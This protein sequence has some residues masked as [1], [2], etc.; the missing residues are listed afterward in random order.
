MH[1][2]IIAETKS[3]KE[4]N[5]SGLS[6]ILLILFLSQLEDCH[7]RNV[8]RERNCSSIAF[9]FEMSENLAPSKSHVL[10]WLSFCATKWSLFPT[11]LNCFQT[12]FFRTQLFKEKKKQ[13]KRGR[14]WNCSAQ[15][16]L[17]LKNILE[18]EGIESQNSTF[19]PCSFSLEGTKWSWINLNQGDDPLFKNETLSVASVL[20]KLKP[21]YI[22]AWQFPP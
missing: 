4:Q 2:V 5:S 9:I 18:E 3:V 10:S 7:S 6:T 16:N 11:F 13:S 22:R 17:N 14:G 19:C 15:I 21:W 20:P 1:V 8:Q 12:L